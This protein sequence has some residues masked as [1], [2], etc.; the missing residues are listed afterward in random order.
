VA[1]GER[2]LKESRRRYDEAQKAL[3]Q[4]KPTLDVGKLLEDDHGKPDELQQQATATVQGIVNFVRARQLAALPDPERPKVFDMP[5]A[6]WGF[7][8][9]SMAAP[10]E[11]ARDA[12]LYIDPIDRSWTNARKQEHLRT[13]NRPVMTLTLIHEVVG[14]FLLGERNRRAPTTMQKIALAPGFLEGWPH[15]VER[16]MLDEGF[17]ADDWKVR[18]AVERSVLLRAARLVAVVR[19]HA[20]GAKLDDIAEM[21]S[22]DALLDE[23]QARREAE[24]AATDP[25]VMVD[26]LGRVAIERLRD[27]WRTTHPEAPLGAFHDA[28]LAH[29]SPPVAVL[30]QIL[31]PGHPGQLL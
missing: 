6:Q 3:A 27:D 10:L 22:D 1:L 18:I 29:G 23:F 9:L 12:Y 11:R 24:R 14:H 15:Y 7:V 8:L 5:P 25:L 2:E 20:L 26:A 16:M 4:G 21:F 19:L 28:L 13:F 30:R 17:A 31:L